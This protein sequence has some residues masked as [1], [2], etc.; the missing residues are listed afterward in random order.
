MTEPE[1]ARCACPDRKL[2]R[3][4]GA[5]LAVD[6][7]SAVV[8]FLDGGGWSACFGLSYRDLCLH[9]A[10]GQQRMARSGPGELR[11]LTGSGGIPANRNK[12]VR[13]FLERTRGE[14]LLF[15]DTDMGF[16]R[17]SLDRLIG[18]ADPAT[19]P[20][21]GGLCF[22]GVRDKAGS[23]ASPL[24]SERFKIVPTVYEYVET[25][26]EIG[27]RP[28]PDY[29]RD[30][31]IEVAG[32][33]AAMLLIHRSALEKVRANQGD[34]WFDPIT[35]PTALK[36]GPRTFSEDLSFCVRLAACGIPVHVDTAVK[37]THE[38]GMAFLDEDAFDQQLALAR[39]DKEL[40]AS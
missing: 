31:V 16:T 27:F 14:W 22:A 4:V 2:G 12:V 7:G 34:A 26:D 8:G 11:A 9:D 21:M 29:A 30:Q 15:I 32:T 18:S 24:Y 3:H 37:T 23:A 17:D 38:K 36:G 5:C 40:E 28:I 35:H 6:P 10:F 39:L 33:G 25:G 1:V 19:R 13:G 20:V